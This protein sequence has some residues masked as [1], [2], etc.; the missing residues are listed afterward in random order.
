MLVEEILEKQSGAHRW[1][2]AAGDADLYIMGLG[3]LACMAQ[4]TGAHEQDGSRME[5]P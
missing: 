5:D 1:L 2:K 3:L 4:E